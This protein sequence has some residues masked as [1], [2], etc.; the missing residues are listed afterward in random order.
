MG[1]V[2]AVGRVGLLGAHPRA[3]VVANTNEQTEVVEGLHRHLVKVDGLVAFP[4]VVAGSSGVPPSDGAIANE[5]VTNTDDEIFPLPLLLPPQV[6]TS[7]SARSQK[8]CTSEMLAWKYD[9]G[10][11]HCL[12]LRQAGTS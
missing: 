12:N 8:K 9:V 5:Q 4:R 2:K 3:I 11:I 1:V 6:P 10:L 7:I